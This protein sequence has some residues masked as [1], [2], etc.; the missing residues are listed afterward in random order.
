LAL[1][2]SVIVPVLV[3]GGAARAADYTVQADGSFEDPPAI[4][5]LADGDSVALLGDAFLA[6]P[7]SISGSVTLA[8]AA[9]GSTLTL[10]S[11]T[12]PFLNSA[13]TLLTLT[14]SDV[15][16]TGAS[17]T[18]NGGIIRSSGAVTIAGALTASNNFAQNLGAVIYASGALTVTG[19]VTLSGNYNGRS[20]S[21]NNDGGSI[22]AGSVTLA[23]NG[24]DVTLTNN[25]VGGGVFSL[26]GG[27]AVYSTGTVVIGGG[28]SVID[29]QGNT[30]GLPDPNATNPNGAYGSGGAIYAAGNATLSGSVITLSGNRAMH[31][32]GGVY[33]NGGLVTINGD[34]T[35][36]DNIAAAGGAIYAATGATIN[37]ALSASGNQA[38]PTTAGGTVSYPG[39]AVVWTNGGQIVVT[40]DV[41]VQDN[42]GR[43]LGAFAAGGGV[44]LAT[45]SGDVK[46]I[47]NT[48]AGSGG[49]ASAS[50][51]GAIYTGAIN[52]LPPG[53]GTGNVTLGN[54]TSSV[55]IA[56]NSA[57]GIMAYV[58]GQTHSG[59]GG[60]AGG[61][62][63]AGGVVTLNGSTI[64]LSGNTA[65]G[66]GGGIFGG[67]GVVIN[68]DITAS[69]NISS[70]TGGNGGG[71]GAIS[72]GTPGARAGFVSIHGS[73]TAN[74]NSAGRWGGAIMSYGGVSIDGNAG[75]NN[76]SAQVGGAI[77]A[78]AG[79]VV[80]NADLSASN[81]SASRDGG[82][83]IFAQNPTPATPV[84]IAVAGNVDLENNK[85]QGTGG[86]AGVGGAIAAAGSTAASVTLATTPGSSVRLLNNRANDGGAIYS[87][88]SITLGNSS[89]TLAL[90][91]NS[92]GLHGGALHAENSITLFSGG[93]ISS[94]ISGNQ[95]G[96]LGGA[97]YAG[98]SVILNATVSDITF[99]GNRQHVDFDAAGLPV[100]GTGS[101]NAI[102][103]DS[104]TAPA[105]LTFNANGSTITL[106]PVENNAA[107]GLVTVVAQGG[108]IVKF[109]GLSYTSAI[110][111][112]S[113]LYGITTVKD[114]TT[115]M[116]W[117]D[118]VFGARAAD[119]G[120][121]APASFTVETGST[122][123]GTGGITS[124]TVTLATGA[125]LA[126]GGLVG[127]GAPVVGTLT[128]TG[129]L[130]LDA[131]TILNYQF[132]QHDVVG[133]QLNDLLVVNGDLTLAGSL[134][135]A[136]TPS[137][138]FLPGTYRVISYTGALNGDYADG[139]FKIDDMP[140]GSQEVLE[141]KPNEVNLIV[142]T[143]AASELT[144]WDGVA[145]PHEDHEVDGGDG[146]W[147][148]SLGNTDWT[149]NTGTLLGTWADDGF[150]IFRGTP[151]DVKV[152]DDEGQVTVAGMQF[153]VSGYVIL[154][155]DLALV[156]APASII[157]VGLGAVGADYITTIE[158]IL[159]GDSQLA[160]EDVGILVLTAANTYTGGS[161]INGGVLRVS[162]NAN[163]GNTAG[164]LSFNG[165][166][167]NTTGTFDSARTGTLGA[168][169][170][171][172]DTNN[173]TALTLSGVLGGIGPLRKTGA[174]ALVLTNT[175]T[176]GGGTAIDG[177]VLRIDADAKLGAVPA[178]LSFNGG[179]LNTTGSFNS[180]R[181]TTLGALGGTFDTNSDTVLAMT[182]VI[183][184]RD[185]ASAGQLRKTGAGKLL[186]TNANT[187]TG[188]TTIAAGTLQL[189]GDE[190]G[191][192]TSGS[193]VG[194]V[195]DSAALVFN[196]SNTL[197]VPGQISG[198]GNVTQSGDGTTILTGNNTY[199]GGTSITGGTLQLGDGGN[200][201]SITGNVANDGALAFKRANVLSFDGV[202]SGGGELDQIGQGTTILTKDSSAFT[203][204]TTVQSGTLRVDGALG[205]SAS[206]V[207]VAK[208][209]TLGGSG[210]LGGSVSIGA[211]GI[212]APNAGGTEAVS[213]LTIAGNLDLDPGAILNYNFGKADV[214]AGGG[215]LNDLVNV[216]GELTLGGTLNVTVTSGGRF[217]PGLY[218]VFNYGTLKGDETDL[219]PGTMPPGSEV[220]VQPTSAAPGQVNLFVKTGAIGPPPPPGPG[221]GPDQ[222]LTFW[223]GA[224]GPHGNGV[225]DGGDGLW[226]SGKGNDNWTD[227][228][229]T[230]IG[231]WD[232]EGFAIF[233]GKG[234]LVEVDDSVGQVAA[235]GMQF[236]VDG[237]VVHGDALRLV[238]N[239]EGRSLLRVGDGS[240][241]GANY[242]ASIDATLTGATQLA[243]RDFGTLVL[244]GSNTYSGG[245]AMDAGV[246]RVSADANL[247]AAQGGL[248]FNGGVLNTSA[249]F[250]SGRDVMLDVGGGAIDVDAGTRLDM[251]G[252][253]TGT[254][255]L[256]KTGTGT[257]VFNGSANTYSGA[258]SVTAGTLQAGKANTFSPN[259]AMSVANTGTIDLDGFAQAVKGLSNAGNVK[260]GPAIAAGAAFTPAVLS[261]NGD[262][263]GQGGTL[264]MRTQLGDDNS[265]TD[266]MVVSGDVSGSTAINLANANGLGA[267]T[268]D[269][270][271][272]VQ[273]GGNSAAEAFTLV[274]GAIDAGAFRYRL[275]EGL[276]A[277]TG[278]NWYLRSQAS[279]PPP[280]PPRPPP[281]PPPPPEYRPE[282]PWL[283]AL[284]SELRQGDLDMLGTLHKRM[285]D[286][287]R[288]LDERDDAGR[289]WGRFLAS[290][291]R[292]SLGNL[293]S[294]EIES[295]KRGLQFGLDLYETTTRDGA[296]HDVGV[297]AGW[298]KADADV[299][300]I[301]GGTAG[302]AWVGNLTPET[303]SLGAYWTYKT[304]AHFYLDA[305][306]QKSWY[307]GDG[308]A[309]TGVATGIGGGGFLASLELGYGVEVSDH[310]QLE[311]QGQLVQV[312]TDI[313]AMAIPNATVNHGNQSARVGRLG[314]RLLGDYGLAGD[315]MIKPYL[316]ANLWQSF[317]GDQRTSFV[318]AAAVTPV[319]TQTNYRSGELGGGFSLALG[320][321][322]SLYAEIDRMF[323]VGGKASATQGTSGSIGFRFD[324]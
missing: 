246:L 35:A 294:P 291:T 144:F 88:G 311:P 237:Y 97:I 33:S 116:V 203:G 320:D 310:W 241:L 73:L 258:T 251:S 170:G 261:V 32:G 167:L 19:A 227:V 269:G 266:R 181:A 159:K 198:S 126:P 56:N 215:L 314:F 149:D 7:L 229:G 273:V 224:A 90:T 70:S 185:I 287:L 280:P 218:R 296:H 39:G 189:G 147:Q 231:V 171:T 161:A 207:V 175:N 68:G 272:L 255:A 30:A 91:G 139:D 193:I 184:N 260:F 293:T 166:T 286:D 130:A 233:Q 145:G 27:G 45:E 309:V 257:L 253:F 51:G 285:G 123:A 80:I 157:R 196:R 113:P 165:G 236:A 318:N 127:S 109:D 132:G 234:G 3:A 321:G 300:G 52:M 110:D 267:L 34:V 188:G 162:A 72:A 62:I 100:A 87:K 206:T 140:F 104:T 120:Q 103:L 135:V 172:I 259:S 31:Y 43:V 244:N 299:A 76:N 115:F 202:I 25:G 315:K 23:A 168:L 96:V 238:S 65:T 250:G 46:L 15:S 281:P 306:L 81:N 290:D 5:S 53:G 18:G 146:T 220:F 138:Q 254:G 78:Y 75:L 107:N 180:G 288:G 158:S 301:T 49:T 54:S 117:N 324:W 50:A 71:G 41:D 216:G 187:Y 10:G 40:G 211:G 249:S 83:V 179:T 82:G 323:S 59:L 99:S 1:L 190:A 14:L 177:G 24:S 303:T 317:G 154:G 66:Y 22:R 2:A 58:G 8:G 192:G 63:F 201:G 155:G 164:A 152:D 282:V 129:D 13:T 228:T 278:E 153:E 122:L 305:V 183:A 226:Q 36:N 195:L 125:I 89:G 219:A 302:S 131:G 112:T 304:P 102:Y 38:V 265:P 74:G 44:S 209:A 284:S 191:G 55:T 77:T 247:G 295:S 173:D 271:M 276:P 279:A 212:L 61:A 142:T 106:D 197:A 217:D 148:N 312:S 69:E 94:N 176:Y 124:D 204:A 307:S 186:L 98:G 133:G 114:A 221:P 297:Y 239:D 214:A 243:K 57:T 199:A 143:E 121:V 322:I 213:T 136:M 150:A 93:D 240:A 119:A 230:P 118:A 182:G 289:L 105:T 252:A 156:G 200:T 222:P 225:V 232:D 84:T 174:G 47:G 11:T 79:D 208:D 210:T 101:A 134:N 21:S 163:L 223:D 9:T 111:L 313:D 298:L 60:A 64:T 137:G 92:A 248:S 26:I 67:S 16:F 235:V 283:S 245:T 242:T 262:Y 275:F 6:T 86:T 263:V 37:G 319:L 277:G 12:S 108:G 151:G 160:K 20:V 194:D 308:A 169:G 264:N 4:T 205:D 95:A 17:V 48:L 29:I 268:T 85:A 42:V 274:G 270:I 256:A 316:R 178:P 141:V 292:R 128:V 28:G